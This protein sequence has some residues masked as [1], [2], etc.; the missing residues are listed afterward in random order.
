MSYPIRTIV[1][2]VADLVEADAVLAPAIQLAHRADAVLHLVH[3]FD[4]PEMTWDI[5]T[6]IGYRDGEA[7]QRHTAERLTELER[8]VRT[9][10]RSERVHCHAIPHAAAQALHLV[11]KRE[12]ADLILTGATRHG[13][14]G[15]A[16]LGTTAQ[17]VLRDSPAPVLVIRDPLPERLSR[18]LL[19]T[20][21]SPFSAGIH[22]LGLDVVEALCRDDAP[23][24]RSLLVVW[25]GRELPP[26]LR[27]DLLEDGARRELQKFLRERRSRATPVTGVVRIGEPADGIAAE[28]RAW[29]PDLLVL[30]THGRR[31]AAR[32]VLGS[33]A[34]AALRSTPGAALVVPAGAYDALPL[35]TEAGEQEAE[36]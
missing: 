24:I 3:A 30:G 32:W 16:I 8:L 23:D 25:Y 17:R 22:E 34:E 9:L 35:D 33:V 12:Q 26:P 18:V 2:G 10:T 7:V 5:Y 11:A 19:T 21:L 13:L 28:V 20:D 31:G 14:L 15:R 29:Q 1:A 36:S 4:L 6:R 27:S